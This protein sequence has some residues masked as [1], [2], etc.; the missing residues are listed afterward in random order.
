APPPSAAAPFV[1]SGQTIELPLA[2]PAAHDAPLPCH[3]TPVPAAQQ[4]PESVAGDELELS[5]AS[6]SRAGPTGAGVGARR[7]AFS[8]AAPLR[9][10]APLRA[11][12]GDV[13]DSFNHD[14]AA[15]ACCSTPAGLFIPL[16]EFERR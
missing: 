7:P 11:A 16:A 5:V 14:G 9:L 2:L 3:S 6:S 15:V 12:L 13:V 1:H 4:R 10:D 8:L